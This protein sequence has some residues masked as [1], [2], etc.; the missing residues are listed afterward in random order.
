M[1]QKRGSKR[2]SHAEFSEEEFSIR[3]GWER[4]KNLAGRGG[5]MAWRGATAPYRIIKTAGKVTLILGSGVVLTGL[6][7]ILWLRR[8]KSSGYDMTSGQ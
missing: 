3:E 6:A 2:S 4:S 5:R 7:A 1:A 8:R